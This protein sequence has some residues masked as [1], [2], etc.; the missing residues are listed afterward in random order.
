MS[1]AD[2]ARAVLDLLVRNGA[3]HAVLSPGSRSAP[4]AFALEEYERAG[5]LTLHTRIDERTAGFLALGLARGSRRPV[6]VVCTSG[7]AAAN[8]HPAMLE[9]A[10]GG[11]P[12]VAVT[13]DRPASLRGTSANQTT[14]QVALF[15]DAVASWDLATPEELAGVVVGDGPVQLNVQF[16][17]P[18]VPSATT[19]PPVSRSPGCH[20]ERATDGA[21][22]RRW[23]EA[24]DAVRLPP[25][26]RTVVVAGDGAGP[27]ARGLAE[28]AGWPLLAEPSSGSRTGAN[29]IRT[30]R[31]LLAGE[32]GRQVERVVVFGHPTL[33]RPVSRLLAEAPEVY[34]VPPHGRWPDLPTPVTGTAPGYAAEADDPAWLEAWRAADR[35]LSQLLD[36]LVEEQGLGPHAVARE[37]SAAVPP[38]GSLFVGASNPVRDLDLMATTYPVGERR[39]VLANRGLAGIDG[40]VSSAIGAALTRPGQRHLALLGDVTFLHDATGL[41]IGPA[42]PRPDL[43]IVVVNDDGGSI[44]ATLEQG[45]PAFAD[46]FERLFGTPHGVDLAALCAATRTPHWRVGSVPELRQALS[47]PN[48]GVEVVEARVRRDDRRDVDERIRGLVG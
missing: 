48:G 22:R 31:L 6:P 5:I 23:A 9:A 25:G 10:H 18:L 32:L 39:R 45:A 29:P 43:T 7:T 16:T 12:L 42:E 30:Y 27:A 14:D 41:V 33:S 24:P 35:A 8:L 47:T 1:S 13:A 34:A 3:E 19:A 21:P 4:L 17:E 46:R 11:L 36:G 26:P 38:G 28:R 15:G 20:G 37:V 40:T 44:F 2:L